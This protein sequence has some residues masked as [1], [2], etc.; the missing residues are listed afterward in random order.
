MQLKSLKNQLIATTGVSSLVAAGIIGW[1]FW[2]SPAPLPDVGLEALPPTTPNEQKI[3]AGT[4]K[5]SFEDVWN[6]E[7]R[8]PKMANTA[9]VVPTLTVNTDVPQ[10]KFAIQLVGTMIEGD[11]SVGFFSDTSGGIDMKSPGEDLELSPSGVRVSRIE[12]AI[13]FVRYMGQEI[14]LEFASSPPVALTPAATTS[15]DGNVN[16]DTTESNRASMASIP[17]ASTTSGLN[18]STATPP[19]PMQDTGDL[20]DPLPL[21]LDPANDY[22]GYQRA[23][24]PPPPPPD[25]GPMQ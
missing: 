7:L 5:L 23:F 4:N 15:E 10:S 12:P 24:A 2:N 13:A 6:L 18:D 11:Q 8:G 25:K 19:P 22:A 17:P 14:R 21:G 16:T 20:S 3:V 1:A 9:P